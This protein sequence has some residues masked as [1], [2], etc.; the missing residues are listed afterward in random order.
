MGSLLV[1]YL[2][3]FWL[4]NLC[5]MFCRDTTQDLLT[6]MGALYSACLFLGVNNSS[7]VQPVVSIERTVFYRE[8]AAGMYSP[9][10]YAAAQVSDFGCNL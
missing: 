2:T 9:F 4:I 7:S 8:K 5:Q 1:G 10:P 6:V 3:C